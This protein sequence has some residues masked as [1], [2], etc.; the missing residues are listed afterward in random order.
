MGSFNIVRRTADNASLKE[1]LSCVPDGISGEQYRS[2]L[3]SDTVPTKGMVN[4]F[5]LM[6]IDPG[7]KGAV[8]IIDVRTSVPTLV[9]IFDMPTVEVKVGG[10]KRNRIDALSLAFTIDSY[11]LQ[12][13][14]ALVEEVGQVGTDADPFSMFVFGFA[15]GVVNGILNACLI[16]NSMVKPNIWKMEIGV[17]SDK[18]TS[19]DKALRLFPEA[20]SYIYL[21]KHD[22][23]AEA[24]LLAWY[25]W[26]KLERK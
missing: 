14:H 13:H 7:I 16:P 21:K 2:H 4:R 24:L 10:K 5:Y 1:R 15:T 18:Q 6:G 23:R 25:L 22:G 9:S 12:L 11:C 26:K 17:S 8:A 3:G 19:I 20:K